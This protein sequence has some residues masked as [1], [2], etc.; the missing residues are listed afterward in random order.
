MNDQT[1]IVVHVGYVLP[2]S[3]TELKWWWW[4]E[5]WFIACMVQVESN[6]QG[7]LHVHAAF[8]K[9]NYIAKGEKHLDHT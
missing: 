1:W 5:C 7:L 9:R 4:Y 6:I 3:G 2:S 8:Q